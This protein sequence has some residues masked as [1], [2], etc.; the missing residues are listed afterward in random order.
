VGILAIYGAVMPEMHRFT[1][2]LC[3]ILA[4]QQ[5]DSCNW[6]LLTDEAE[7]VLP[8]AFVR[9]SSVPKTGGLM[10]ERGLF[11]AKAAAFG[12]CPPL[13]S[14]AEERHVELAVAKDAGAPPLPPVSGPHNYHLPC[15]GISR[16]M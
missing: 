4:L 9:I 3:A 7:R 14:A 16:A 2:A 10:K 5:V 12:P 8:D 11:M 15:A 1:L 13:M 6:P